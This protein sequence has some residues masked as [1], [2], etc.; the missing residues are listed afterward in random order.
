MTLEFFTLLGSILFFVK[1]A[2]KK[3]NI[4]GITILFVSIIFYSARIVP[5]YKVKGDKCES[6]ISVIV[7]V[8]VVKVP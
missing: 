7:V 3:V 2:V 5:R 8:V 4:I 6:C 1:S